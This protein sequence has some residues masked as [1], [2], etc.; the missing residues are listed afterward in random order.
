MKSEEEHQHDVIKPSTQIG[1]EVMTMNRESVRDP[2][3]RT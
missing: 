1:S 3:D 2:T